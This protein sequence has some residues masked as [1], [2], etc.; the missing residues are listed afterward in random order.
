MSLCGWG[1]FGYPMLQ[2]ADFLGG[3]DL[4]Y[5]YSLC[6]SDLAVFGVCDA[7]LEDLDGFEVSQDLFGQKRGAWPH[8]GFFPRVGSSKKAKAA[9]K[10]CA[11]DGSRIMMIDLTL[12]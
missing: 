7:C 2:E 1:F 6:C 10:T 8:E 5:A 9:T 12:L 11:L 4:A 3:K